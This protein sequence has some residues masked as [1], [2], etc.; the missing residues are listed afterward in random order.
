[1]QASKNLAKLS[2]LA[3]SLAAALPAGA[4]DITVTGIDGSMGGTVKA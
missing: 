4:S 1:M 3:L 2:V